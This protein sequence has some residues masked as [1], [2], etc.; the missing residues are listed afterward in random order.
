MDTECRFEVG[1]LVE[2]VFEAL[3]QSM[4][5]STDKIRLHLNLTDHTIPGEERCYTEHWEIGESN[6]DKSVTYDL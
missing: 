6:C 4:A 1:R 5:V 2:V 3:P